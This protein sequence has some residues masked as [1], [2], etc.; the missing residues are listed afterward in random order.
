MTA[1]VPRRVPNF[2][3]G[4]IT[5]ADGTKMET[6]IFKGFTL[7]HYAMLLNTFKDVFD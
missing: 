6:K 3:T 7:E 5:L 4:E 1:M 2:E